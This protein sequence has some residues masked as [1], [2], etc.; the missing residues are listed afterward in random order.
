MPGTDIADQACNMYTKLKNKSLLKH[1]VERL[2]KFR[3]KRKTKI[4]IKKFNKKCFKA[5]TYYI[6]NRIKLGNVL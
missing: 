3:I 2:N 6:I 4:H 5:L 1:N